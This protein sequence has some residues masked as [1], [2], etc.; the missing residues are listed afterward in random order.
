M[1]AIVEIS[2]HQYRIGAGDVIDVEKLELEESK[3]VELGQV[4]FV[5]GDTPLIGSPVVSGAIVKA[6]ILKHDKSRKVLVQ[7]NDLKNEW[8]KRSGHRQEYTSLLITQINNGQ[9]AV[10]D[11]DKESKN[12]KKYL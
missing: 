11:I 6:K 7:R 8:K 3:V 2:G 12:A 5:S 1:Y 9:G 4:M 10:E